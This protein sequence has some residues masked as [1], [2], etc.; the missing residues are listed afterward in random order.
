MELAE[1]EIKKQIYLV[2]GRQVMLDSALAELFETKTKVLNQAV[3][4][5]PERFPEDFMFQLNDEEYRNVRSQGVT[6]KSGRGSH[7]KYLPH[8]FTELG[9][10]ML[11]SILRNNRAI[12]VNIS[13]I[14][15]FA[16]QR[17]S[18]QLGKE[19]LGELSQLTGKVDQIERIVSRQS[20]VIHQAIEKNGGRG[21]SLSLPSEVE[22]QDG[23][24]HLEDPSPDL[25]APAQSIS[26]A[27]DLSSPSVKAK[28]SAKIAAFMQGTAKYYGVKVSDLKSG[29]RISSVVLPRQVAIY[30]IRKHSSIGLKEIGRIFGGRDHTTTLHAY[31]KIEEALKSDAT[32]Q[33]AITAVELMTLSAESS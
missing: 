29:T 5:N 23:I 21:P 11:S 26:Q 14:R 28:A 6:L 33:D 18:A 10:G 17:H 24:R 2:R 16:H 27:P 32:I 31:R 12:Q 8:V 3:R 15:A 30:L 1:S 20:Q 13:V 7:T 4:R 22:A 19:L 9:V 25:T